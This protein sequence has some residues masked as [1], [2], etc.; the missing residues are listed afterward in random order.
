MRLHYP[1]LRAEHCSNLQCLHTCPLRTTQCGHTTCPCC[2][3]TRTSRG[4]RV[5]RSC[6]LRRS[7]RR[8]SRVEPQ[9][10]CSDRTS[11]PWRRCSGPG[12][13]HSFTWA[14][15]FSSR[16]CEQAQRRHRWWRIP[17]RGECATSSR[18][19]GSLRSHYCVWIWI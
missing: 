8:G 12:S 4:P 6:S 3:A 14:R 13:A 11:N 17:Y 18:T 2:R 9:R 5:T 15:S 16:T 19:S 1:V 10:P 7:A